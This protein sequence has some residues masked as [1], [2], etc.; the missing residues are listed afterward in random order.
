[1]VNS[2]T[3][4]KTNSETSLLDSIA[5][6]KFTA[7]NSKLFQNLLPLLLASKPL[8]LT[9]PSHGLGSETTKAIHKN[10]RMVSKARI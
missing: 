3:D 9:S 4:L 2:L 10:K 8:E 6:R 7:L 5:N 1:M